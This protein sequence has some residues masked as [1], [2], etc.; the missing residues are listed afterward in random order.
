M[1][2]APFELERTF[3][4]YEHV[5]GMN[6]LGASDA[7]TLTVDQLLKMSREPVDLTRLTLGYGDTR[8]LWELRKAIAESYETEAIRPE[9]VLVTVGASEAI[10]LALHTMMKPNDT[11]LVCEPAYQ[12]LYEMASAAGARVIKYGFNEA[13]DG[14]APDLDFIQRTLSQRPAPDLLVLNSPHNPTGHAFDES[15]MKELLALARENG[16]RV[17]VDEVF[18]G[19]VINSEQQIQSAALLDQEASVIGSFSKVYGLAG[20]RVGWLVGKT[21]FIEQC[22]DLRYYTVL[23][24]PSIVQQLAI[25]AIENKARILARTQSNVDE[26]FDYVRRWLDERA[27]VLDWVRPTAGLVMLI[28]LKSDRNTAEFTG[29][30]AERCKVFLVPCTTCFGMPEG[31][32]RLGLGGNPAAFR[33]GLKVFDN[34]LRTQK[35]TR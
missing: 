26:N 30:L 15:S 31:F 11:A 3:A 29:E 14:F 20:L 9:N 27:D 24:P 16:T 2:F 1:Q 18:L 17:L 22:I 6:V 12:G 28:R 10:F 25:I 13:N 35:C 7:E 34:Y 32:L 23:V 4:K 33:A 5:P 19:V 8:G 21:E